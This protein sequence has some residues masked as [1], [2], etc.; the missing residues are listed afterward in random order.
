MP[1]ANWT[2]SEMEKPGRYWTPDRKR[3]VAEQ[4]SGGGLSEAEACRRYSMSHQELAIWLRAYTSGSGFK[5]GSLIELAR[6][7]Q[8]E[9]VRTINNRVKRLRC[10]KKRRKNWK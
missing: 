2:L 4:V 10:I 7:E 6:A 8:E 1:R 5:V 3:R 9:V